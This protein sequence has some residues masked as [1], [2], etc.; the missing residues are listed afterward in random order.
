M[1]TAESNLIDSAYAWWL[2]KR[3]VGSSAGEHYRNP[4]INTTSKE[5]FVL[6]H[7]VAAYMQEGSQKK[8]VR[9]EIKP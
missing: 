2:T 1:T 9:R 3:P 6:A 7:S 8:T 5:E 4:T